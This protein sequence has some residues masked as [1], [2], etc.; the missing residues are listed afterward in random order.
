[1]NGMSDVERLVG[2]HVMTPLRLELPEMILSDAAHDGRT[3][4][5]ELVRDGLDQ[6]LLLQLA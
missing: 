6:L 5:Y 3:K 4:R 1:V 2:Q